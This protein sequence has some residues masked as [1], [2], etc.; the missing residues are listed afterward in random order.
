MI[1][2]NFRVFLLNKYVYF[3][4]FFFDQMLH[5]QMNIFSYFKSINECFAFLSTI[6]LTQNKKHV[7]FKI[8]NQSIRNRDLTFSNAFAVRILTQH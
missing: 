5:R 4:V 1:N 2:S 3:F 7:E 8:H 6:K